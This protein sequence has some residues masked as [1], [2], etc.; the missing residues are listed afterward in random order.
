MKLFNKNVSVAFN[1]TKPGD[2]IL[3]GIH[4]FNGE[5]ECCGDEVNVTEIGLGI[6]GMAIM[7][8]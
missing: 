4:N 6:V 5:M 8:Q 3:F 7:V 2:P 1:V